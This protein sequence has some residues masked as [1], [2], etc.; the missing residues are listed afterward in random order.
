M[1]GI[2]ITM[3]AR[4]RRDYSH[5]VLTSSLQ[6][7]NLRCAKKMCPLASSHVVLILARYFCYSNFLFQSCCQFFLCNAFA[8]ELPEKIALSILALELMPFLQYVAECF[9]SQNVSPFLRC[10]LLLPLFQKC[11][12]RFIKFLRYAVVLEFFIFSI[13]KNAIALL[14]CRFQLVPIL[15]CCNF[16][17]LHIKK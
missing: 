7:R 1:F 5:A 11:C 17:F 12:P 10:C 2:K 6:M 15:S 3:Y 13:Q 4:W 9:C 8:L 16:M 14:W